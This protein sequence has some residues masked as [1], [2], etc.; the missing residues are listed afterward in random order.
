[1]YFLLLSTDFYVF[2]TAL[3]GISA[4][5]LSSQAATQTTENHNIIK[6]AEKV[7]GNCDRFNP[8]CILIKFYFM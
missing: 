1:M 2:V 7:I 6:D 3:T 8:V 5:Y 4:R